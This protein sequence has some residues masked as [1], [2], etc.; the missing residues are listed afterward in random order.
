VVDMN[1]WPLVWPRR[2]CRHAQW[3]WA[4]SAALGNR[5]SVN[6]A[7]LWGLWLRS[8]HWE[9][10]VAAGHAWIMPTYMEACAVVAIS[11]CL[12]D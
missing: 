7:S 4:R 6:R 9:G 12:V 5:V 8:M 11:W 1:V 10:I 2:P 3:V